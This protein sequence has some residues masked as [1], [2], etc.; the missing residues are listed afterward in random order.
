MAA[1][2]GTSGQTVQQSL[3]V[4]GLLTEGGAKFWDIL[5]SL[6]LSMR[7]ENDWVFRL[8]L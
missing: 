1:G 7:L 8:A 6:N 4:A 3:Q 5:P 2:G